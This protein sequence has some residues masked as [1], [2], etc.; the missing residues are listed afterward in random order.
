ML[1][2]AACSVVC[3]HLTFATFLQHCVEAPKWC[4]L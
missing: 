1:V 2:K 4:Q 3:A